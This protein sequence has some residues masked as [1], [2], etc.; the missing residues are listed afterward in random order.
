MDYY[1]WLVGREW[2]GNVSSQVNKKEELF[3]FSSGLAPGMGKC[4]ARDGSCNI[5]VKTSAP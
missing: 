1:Y 2:A 3:L 5:A 4:Q